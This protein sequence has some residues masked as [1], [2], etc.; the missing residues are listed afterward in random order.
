MREYIYKDCADGPLSVQIDQ[1]HSSDTGLQSVFIV[2]SNKVVQAYMYDINLAR[3]L[4]EAYNEIL[5][6]HRV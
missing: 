3:K 6:R 1:I 5:L 4:V 2:D